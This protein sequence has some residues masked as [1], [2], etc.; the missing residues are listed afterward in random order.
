MADDIKFKGLTITPADRENTRLFGD[1]GSFTVRIPLPY[2]KLNI[3]SNC[4]RVMA[5]ASLETIYAKDYEYI[6]MIVTL[7]Q[8][9]TK[10]PD[11]WKNA[12]ECPDE[13]LLVELWKFYLDSQSAFD[14]K[15]R[16][17]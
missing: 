11:W 3:L 13:E 12:G 4:S 9:V 1:K 14:E 16:K 6:R 5:G 7:N 10:G 2:E 17:N 15:I 8:V